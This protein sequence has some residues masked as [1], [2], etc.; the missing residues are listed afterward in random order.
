MGRNNADFS[1][2]IHGGGASNPANW[3]NED[4]R[5]PSKPQKITSDFEAPD[6]ADHYEERNT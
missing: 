2:G 4:N 3:G 5:K 6:Y 1:G